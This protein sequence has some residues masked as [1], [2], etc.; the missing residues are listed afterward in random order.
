[1]LLNDPLTDQIRRL[2]ETGKTVA[3]AAAACGLSKAATYRRLAA[4]G[5]QVDRRRGPTPTTDEE[6]EQILD[7]AAEGKS[8]REIAR[9][10][11]RSV[12]T[13][14]RVAYSGQS[15]DGPRRLRSAKRCPDCGTRIN[16]WPCV[17]CAGERAG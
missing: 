2:V 13:I 8:R 1:M 16:V 14:V 7:L 3:Q 10:V 4:L 17:A 5:D 11:R 9:I 12:S 6:C 15:N